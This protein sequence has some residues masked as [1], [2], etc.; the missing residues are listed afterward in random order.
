MGIN[1]PFTIQIIDSA[2]F[3]HIIAYGGSSSQSFNF[4]DIYN[5]VKMMKPDWVE[6]LGSGSAFLF[7][8]PLVIGD[9]SGAYNS[10][11]TS[12]Q[13][14][15]FIDRKIFSSMSY[16]AYLKIIGVEGHIKSDIEVLENNVA[17]ETIMNDNKDLNISGRVKAEIFE[18]F[19]TGSN[20]SD[21]VSVMDQII[22]AD[23]IINHSLSEFSDSS[24]NRHVDI[25]KYKEIIGCKFKSSIK[26]NIDTELESPEFSKFYIEFM[27]PNVDLN[28]LN[29]NIDKISDIF[30]EVNAGSLA[31]N[32]KIKF[33]SV[34][35]VAVSDMD[36]SIIAGASVK[37]YDQGEEIL[38]S[39][40]TSEFGVCS[41]DFIAYQIDIIAPNTVVTSCPIVEYLNLVA[42]KDM[43]SNSTIFK[44]IKL[45]D[46]EMII[47]S[48][49]IYFT[50][51][52]GMMIDID[53]KISSVNTMS[54]IRGTSRIIK[55][56]VF[57]QNGI[58]IDTSSTN[59]KIKLF[60][61]SFDADPFLEHE[62][63]VV[64]SGGE[65]LFEIPSVDTAKLEYDKY[66]YTITVL[67][68][69]L[70]SDYINIK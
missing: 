47:N 40:V 58:P 60:I 32:N 68:Q 59:V 22:D 3:R 17:I 45:P 65:V 21:H 12:D 61:N 31:G 49:I 16:N 48:E 9:A 30:T 20:S 26:I 5:Q 43:I 14:S 37:V 6:R 28:I 7:R 24:F 10:Y 70:I 25:R 66:F 69:I 46:I 15:V 27:N 1:I 41:V 23:I 52:N 29:V 67:N 62:A 34:S 54:I 8:V 38:F 44:I 50:K 4:Y 56:R 19:E 55:A 53:N 57:D 64:S 13:E 35:D 63:L 2:D 42:V 33:R 11:I 18:I 39:G 36:E 51:L